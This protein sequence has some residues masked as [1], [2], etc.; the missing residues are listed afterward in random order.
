[1]IDLRQR[2]RQHG[3]FLRFCVVGAS[4]VVV[5]LVV[6]SATLQAIGEIWGSVAGQYNYAA[7][8]G[9]VVSVASNFV[10]NDRWTFAQ[11]ASTYA[12]SWGRRLLRYYGSALY[13]M[14]VQLALFNLLLKLLE[15]VTVPSAV[16]P[17]LPYGAYLTGIASGTLVNY[18]MSRRHV[19][20]APSP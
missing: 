18:W 14:G 2:L 13:G 3:Q 7:V 10:L 5:N 11:P 9:W 17:A 16:Q 20:H 15:H 19:F 1:M 12:V 6:F 4:G 8:L